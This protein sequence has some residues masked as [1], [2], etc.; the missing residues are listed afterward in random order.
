MKFF[1][2]ALFL[3]PLFI[4]SQ[5]WISGVST[6]PNPVNDCDNL[7]VTVDGNL[8]SSNCTY[9][10]SFSI[11]GNTIT[12][13]IQVSC[14]GIGLPVITPY[15][16][17]I[18]IGNITSNTY[19]LV[20]NQFQFGN[21][22]ETRTSSLQVGSCCGASVNISNM[23][24]F[25]CVGESTS[26]VDGGTTA[27]SLL[28][29]DNGTP[30]SPFPSPLGWIYSFQDTGLHQITLIAFD[31]SGCADTSYLLVTINPLP[32][33]ITSTIPASCNSCM[34]GEAL[35]TVISGPVPHQLV[36]S[37]GGSSN[38]LTGLNPGD[39]GFSFTDGNTCTRYDTVTVGNSL[40]MDQNISFVS[41]FPNPTNGLV[42]I[43][44]LSADVK[45][46]IYNFEGKYIKSH[47]GSSIDLSTLST[48]IYI[49][50]VIK[51]ESVLNFKVIKQ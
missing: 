48:G 29:T 36:W 7:V 25:S 9:Q 32:E 41:C 23:N 37:V 22:Q 40:G 13:D 42:E 26:F 1:L 43:S 12:I 39:Y 34:D 11:L 21:L 3:T 16:T 5:F 24:S 35:I 27:D 6:S 49:L 28:W 31:T 17:T 44:G 47:L 30:F 8:S 46:D 33:V 14:G 50:N 38:P 19:T 4:F 10:S 51:D 45:I 15:T 18:P 20:V 2:T